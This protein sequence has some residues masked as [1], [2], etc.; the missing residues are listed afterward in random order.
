MEEQ[1]TNEL[2][3]VRLQK[4]H[5]I[6]DS[7]IDPYPA[8]SQKSVTNSQV[9]D[10]FGE[11]SEKNKAI[12]VAGRLMSKR[13]H[14][15][16]I[17][18]EIRDFSADLQI[19][20]KQDHISGKDWEFFSELVDI[21]DFI[22]AKGTLFLTK[23]EEKTLL[24]DKV[25]LLS[26]SL[27]PL[28]EKWHGLQDTE[29]RFRQRYLDMLMNKE[30]KDRF[31]VRHELT[32]AIR[33]FLLKAKYIEVDTPALQPLP[34]GALA[35]PFVTY[36]EA[37]DTNVYLRIAPEL[38]L[39]R[40]IV[41]GYEKVFEFAR[42]FRNEGMSSQHLQDFTMLEFYEAYCDYEK[43]MKFTEKML[44]TVIKQVFGD[45]KTKW[46]D[47]EI[48]W[49]APWP[50]KSFR[51]LILEH[52]DIDINKYAQ[53]DDLQKAITDKGINLTFK[54]FAGCGKLID[55]LYKEKVRPHLKDP[56][57]LVDHPLD[58][59]PLAK[60]KVKDP[61]TVQRFQLVVAGMEIVNAFSELND[62]IDQAERFEDQA[63]Q[64]EAG[65]RDAHTAD[66]DFVKALEYGMPPT[67]GFGM[68]MDRLVA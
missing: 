62:P 49:S 23:R 25:T 41:G 60:K 57:F 5:K 36:Y 4:L 48:N 50:K 59:S 24:V 32:Q 58:L 19:L 8:K 9:L 40:L 43:L 51:E 15:G 47:G 20:I 14:G 38:Y 28:P 63:K 61:K 65:D 64:K 12:S 46:G 54:G 1:E 39:K 30:V 7:K 27:R 21:G 10:K 67:A 17:F 26:K 45:L 68:G 42:V 29:A 16:L 55:E 34:G 37:M 18:A 11:W 3:E 6:R 44:T 56:I 33:N 22:S 2:R 31:V 52:T 35:T 66:D 13:E 53:A